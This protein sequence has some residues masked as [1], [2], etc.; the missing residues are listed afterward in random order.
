MKE[1]HIGK[2]KSLMVA[3]IMIAS[4]MFVFGIVQNTKA[5][6]SDLFDGTLVISLPTH[7]AYVSGVVNITWSG[8]N[9]AGGI[10]P[11]TYNVSFG[12]VEGTDSRWTRDGGNLSHNGGNATYYLWNTTTSGYNLPEGE[13]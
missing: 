9:I 12:R 1:S 2:M 4:A 10:H 7:G 8:V 13:C 11:I 6:A 5:A 3:I